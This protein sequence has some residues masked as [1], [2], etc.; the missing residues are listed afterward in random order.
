MSKQKLNITS[1]LGLYVHIPFCEHKCGYC[2]FYSITDRAEQQ[3]FVEALNREI[4]LKSE[5]VSQNEIVDTIYFGGG[6]PSLLTVDQLNQILLKI[7]NTF[8]LADDCEIT[9]EMNPGATEQE[10]IPLFKQL[11]INRLSI[12]IQSFNDSELKFLERIHNANQ[13][14]AAFDAAR[15]AGFENINIDLIYALP[16]QSLQQW[17]NTLEKVVQLKPEHISAYNLIYEAHT[18][19]YQKLKKGQINKQSDEQEL[20]FFNFTHRFLTTNKYWH[21]EVSNFSRGGKFVSRHNYK[22]W[23]HVPYLGFGPSAHSFYQ[24]KRS[25]NVRSLNT[26]LKKLSQGHL[27]ISFQESLDL[28]TQEFE[29]IL[30]RLRTYAGIDLHD[31][32]QKFGRSFLKMY[33]TTVNNLIEQKMAVLDDNTFALTQKGMAVCDELLSYFSSN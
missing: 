3:T 1:R 8:T 6:T 16:N 7:K 10:K 28:Q 5:S 30:L 4:E 25:A 2:D 20:A 13:A 19:F 31:F 23:L 9:L 33:R 26:Y 12:G 17:K 11:G 18:P 22:Y 32:E 27:P 29:Y 14:M 15:R 24:G 21:Y